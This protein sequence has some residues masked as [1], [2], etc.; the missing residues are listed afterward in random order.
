MTAAALGAPCLRRSTGVDNP[1]RGGGGD[2]ANSGFRGLCCY[3][4]LLPKAVAQLPLNR[5]LL[6]E[7]S[8]I[9][10]FGNGRKFVRWRTSGSTTLLSSLQAVQSVEGWCWEET[11]SEPAGHTV[12]EQC[13]QKWPRLCWQV[14]PCSS[15]RGGFG[16]CQSSLQNKPSESSFDSDRQQTLESLSVGN[17]YARSFAHGDGRGRSDLVSCGGCRGKLR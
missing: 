16:P 5:C 7:A 3:S 13:D 4:L 12:S 17:V 11:V 9:Q 10:P 15:S 1:R 8:A 6:V 2:D 14:P